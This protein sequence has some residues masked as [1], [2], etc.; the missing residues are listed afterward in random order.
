MRR[1]GNGAPGMFQFSNIELLD[2]ILRAFGRDRW[3]SNECGCVNT[4]DE[5][6]RHGQTTDWTG[7]CKF[8]YYN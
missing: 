8:N 1:K 6:K 3:V 7:Q 5:V 4:L 2:F